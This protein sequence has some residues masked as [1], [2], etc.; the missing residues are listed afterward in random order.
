[1]FITTLAIAHVR[2]NNE[3]AHARQLTLFSALHQCARDRDMAVPVF[4]DKAKVLK[5]AEVIQ[6]RLAHA[7][8]LK[9]SGTQAINMQVGTELRSPAL[10][11]YLPHV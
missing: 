9:M 6:A 1:M 7:Q 10:I 2:R 11:L 5:L 4:P 3:I 8:Q